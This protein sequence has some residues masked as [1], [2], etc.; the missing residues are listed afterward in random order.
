MVVALKFV[1]FH[2]HNGFLEIWLELGLAGLL[3]FALS[4]ARGCYKL[5]PVIRGGHARAAAWPACVLL[6]IAAYDFDENTLLSF[7]GLFWVLYVNA[8]VQ[9]EILSRR[10]TA[11][12][13]VVRMSGRMRASSM[14]IPA[15]GRQPLARAG[16]AWL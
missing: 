12:A 14:S 15:L 7:N 1:L 10:Y 3:L 13:A 16:G 2:A 8:L 5:W 4:Y 9:I 6:L 11:P